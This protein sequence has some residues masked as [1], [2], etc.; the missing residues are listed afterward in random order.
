[1]GWLIQ[2]AVIAVVE[3]TCETFAGSR[4]SNERGAAVAPRASLP[5]S[6][7][8]LALNFYQNALISRLGR[9]QSKI[10]T[11]GYVVGLRRRRRPARS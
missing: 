4:S 1:M 9:Q 7:Q 10:T 8:W 6:R 3:G 11:A 5:P 2:T